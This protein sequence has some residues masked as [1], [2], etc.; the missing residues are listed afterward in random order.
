MFL[1]LVFILKWRIR[2]TSLVK[3]KISIEL[4]LYK[5]HNRVIFFFKKV[6]LRLL[7]LASK[8]RQ[9]HEKYGYLYST[10]YLSKGSERTNH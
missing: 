1:V 5:K 2:N 6:F 3:F 4:A 7:P 8:R 9:S 10:G